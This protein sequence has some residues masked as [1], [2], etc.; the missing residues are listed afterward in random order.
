MIFSYSTFIFGVLFKISRNDH[1]DFDT[2]WKN[3]WDLNFGSF[4]DPK[5]EDNRV[6]DY[7]VFLGAIIINVV[8]MLN[9]LISILGDSFEH[10][11]LEKIIIDYREKIEYVY[12]LQKLMPSSK[13][14]KN[15]KYLHVLTS[16]FEDED[17][18]DWDGRII[19]MEKKAEKNINNLQLS[20]IDSIKE[21][22]DSTDKKLKENDCSVA[23]K[24]SSVETKISSVETGLREN[25]S[26][27]ETKITSMEEKLNR[28]LEILAK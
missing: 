1:I 11:Q 25:I 17:S 15:L 20:I 10:F 14:K 2:L 26:S 16:P 21:S 27:V 8:L 28:I 5:Y 12:D 4:A 7:I 13:N 23:T 9:L 24:I 3:S 18:A 19:Y 22:K 6:L